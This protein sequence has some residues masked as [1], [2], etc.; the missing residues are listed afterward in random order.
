MTEIEAA[1]SSG[2]VGW[3]LRVATADARAARKAGAPALVAAL[4]H[5]RR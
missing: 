2:E 3:A 1:L 4:R 5:L